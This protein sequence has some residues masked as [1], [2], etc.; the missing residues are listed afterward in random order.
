MPPKPL[1]ITLGNEARGDDGVGLAVF[2]WLQHNA[3]SYR[4]DVL[5]FT[6]LQPE[7][8][9]LLEGRHAVLIVDCAHQQKELIELKPIAPLFTHYFSSHI[10]PPEVLLGWYEQLQEMPAP[11]CFLLT[12][13]GARF[14]LGETLSA[15]VQ[16]A[17]PKVYVAVQQW[18]QQTPG[19]TAFA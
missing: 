1:I 9:A 2:E 4:A 17:L 8:V 5:H 7:H 3:G 16:Q 12:V 14:E 15:D 11:A 6:Q 10:V 19:A 18:L 13:L